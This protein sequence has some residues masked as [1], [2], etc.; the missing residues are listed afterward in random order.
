MWLRICKTSPVCWTSMGDGPKSFVFGTLAKGDGPKFLVL[1]ANIAEGL[2][3]LFL[4]FENSRAT[5]P[6][7]MSLALWPRATAL[8]QLSLAP[9]PRAT[10]LNHQI[11]GHKW[12]QVKTH[13]QYMPKG[14]GMSPLCASAMLPNGTKCIFYR[15]RRWGAQPQL[16]SGRKARQSTPHNRRQA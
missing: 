6:N 9:W 12:A 11:P 2:Q 15:L 4:S 14:G 1:L 5:A 7:Q 16:L 8:H 3:N 13:I 10:A